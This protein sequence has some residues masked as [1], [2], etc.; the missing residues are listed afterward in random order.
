M[1]DENDHSPSF[2]AGAYTYTVSENAV[3]GNTVVTLAATDADIGVNADVTYSLLGATDVFSINATT[4][5][6]FLL[7]T[8]NREAVMNYTLNVTATDSGQLST[9]QLVTIFVTDANDNAPVFSAPY[10]N[11]SVPEVSQIIK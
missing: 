9:F 1:L 10:Y 11:A 8:L 2:P 6:I 3:I 4:G 5:M 7:Q